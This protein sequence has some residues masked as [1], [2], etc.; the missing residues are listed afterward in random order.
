MSFDLE[1]GGRGRVRMEPPYWEALERVAAGGGTTAERLLGLFEARRADREADLGSALRVA[2]ADWVR[3]EVAPRTGLRTRLAPRDG[4][5]AVGVRIEVGLWEVLWDA[6][7]VQGLRLDELV[8][9]VGGDG[10][11]TQIEAELRAYAM[12]YLLEGA[13]RE[14]RL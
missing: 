1:E 4:R 7:M 2:L 13:D 9:R 11:R 14:G 6:A 8:R 12:R 10:S 5:R 3:G